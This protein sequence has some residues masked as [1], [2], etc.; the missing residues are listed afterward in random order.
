MPRYAIRIDDYYLEWSTIVDAPISYGMSEE[1]YR[2]FFIEEYGRASGHQLEPRMQRIAQ[3][4]TSSRHGD[5]PEQLVVA[6]RAGPDECELTLQEIKR[7][8]CERLP[9]RDGWIEEQWRGWVKQSETP[10]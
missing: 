10:A 8:Y 4:G 7:A 9:I 2:K 6:N 5:T 3:Y 1:E